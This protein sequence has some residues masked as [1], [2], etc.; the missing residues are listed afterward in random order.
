MNIETFTLS[1]SDG[2]M[3]GWPDLIRTKTGRLLCPYNEC[4]AH[5]NRDHTFIALRS[6]DDNGLTWSEARHIGPETMHGDQ[7]N[8]IRTSQL[9]DGR[10]WVVVDRI[11]G[12]ERDPRCRIHIFESL[13]DGETWSGP[14]DTGLHGYCTDKIRALPDG[15]LLLL[16]SVYCPDIGRSAVYAH[17]SEDGGATWSE[18]IEAGRD[19]RYNLIE[20]AALL[21]PGGE[22]VAFMRENSVKG[23]DCIKSISRDGG[24]TWEG[25]YPHAIP[26]CH[27]P[28]VG[29]LR[30]GRILLTY[31]HYEPPVCDLWCAVFD[32]A[33]ALETDRAAQ[34][35]RRGLLDHDP[36]PKPDGGYSGWVQ[37]PD[38]S[39]LAVNYITDDAPRPFI[40][41]YRITGI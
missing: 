37:Q 38:G 10:I 6:S 41:G 34:R 15:S 23:Y 4:T 20:P 16:V 5:G 28:S 25:V 7:Y 11:A 12:H 17:R 29:F 27:R 31:R 18:R 22:I 8:S 35:V 2:H 1:R 39:I 32:A 40:R 24:R 19:T 14:R 36:A 3:E 9:P 21:L 26:C 33:S 30:D 13:D